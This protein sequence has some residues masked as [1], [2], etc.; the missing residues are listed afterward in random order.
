MA[1]GRRDS[2]VLIVF[3]SPDFCGIGWSYL[4]DPKIDS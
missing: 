3:K 2:M 1:R 4:D